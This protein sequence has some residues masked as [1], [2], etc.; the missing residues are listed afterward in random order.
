MEI[1]LKLDVFL[2]LFSF[3]LIFRKFV[4]PYIDFEFLKKLF[5]QFHIHKK[6]RPWNAESTR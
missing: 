3:F 2:F 6:N 1:R 4:D 5:K